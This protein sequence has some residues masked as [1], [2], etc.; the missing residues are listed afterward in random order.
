MKNYYIYFIANF[1]D[2]VVYLGVTNDLRRRVLQHKAKINAECFSAKYNCDKLV[3]YEKYRCVNKA[4]AREKQLKNWKRQWKNE[5]IETM[6]P[7]WNDLF[8]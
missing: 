2:K 7:G 8:R 3:Y 4:I 1:N 5:L 6:N